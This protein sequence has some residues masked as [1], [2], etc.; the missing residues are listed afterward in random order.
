LDKMMRHRRMVHFL[1]SPHT[2][3]GV[4]ARLTAA[5]VLLILLLQPWLA[6]FAK[7]HELIIGG[8]PAIVIYVKGIRSKLRA[9]ECAQTNSAE[10]C[11]SGF[12]ACDSLWV[13]AVDIQIDS[14][15]AFKFTQKGSA[16]DDRKEAIMAVTT[17]DAELLDA[18]A[19]ELIGRAPWLKALEHNN[20]AEHRSVEPYSLKDPLW[21][22]M[23]LPA[24]REVRKAQQISSLLQHALRLLPPGGVAVEFCSGGGYVGIPLAYLRPDCTVLLTDMNSVSLKFAEKRVAALGLRN[25]QILRTELS[26]IEAIVGKCHQANK[27]EEGGSAA[28]KLL[29]SFHLG[30]SLHACGPGTDAVLRICRARGASCVA[31]PCCYGFMQHAMMDA[32][33]P[34]EE[35]DVV[36]RAEGLCRCADAPDRTYCTECCPGPGATTAPPPYTTRDSTRRPQSAYPQSQA[37]REAGWQAAWF[38]ALCAR[39]DRTFWTHDSRAPAHNTAGRLAMRAVDADRLLCMQEAGYE[40]FGT[41]MVPAEASVKNHVLVC[42]CRKADC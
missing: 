37:F 2:Q 10:E 13:D 4:V 7:E 35:A 25:V 26:R 32:E 28:E 39:A 20:D 3:G 6:A 41:H 36:A 9:I 12:T 31:S 14:S 15:A 40:V 17:H 29:T 21:R 16:R 23:C 8:L 22:H 18:T 33:L 27:D 38:A 30:L 24:G 5:D 11:S 42:V 19:Q 34:V 1:D